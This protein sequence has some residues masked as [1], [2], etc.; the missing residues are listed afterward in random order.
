MKTI[1][2]SS[3]TILEDYISNHEEA[4][5]K[6]ILH[7]IKVLQELPDIVI[8]CRLG[9]IDVKAFA[10]SLFRKTATIGIGKRGKRK[11]NLV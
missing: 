6:I 5:T 2:L 9:D 10:I 11:R 1:Y 4:D 3:C 8:R 7:A